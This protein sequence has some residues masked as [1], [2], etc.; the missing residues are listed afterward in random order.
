MTLSIYIEYSS[1]KLAGI[2]IEPP[3]TLQSGAHF[4]YNHGFT[5]RR[6]KSAQVL[7]I[8]LS[9]ITDDRK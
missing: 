8:A 4:F 3:E 1:A 6:N 5:R 9:N 2:F 7:Q